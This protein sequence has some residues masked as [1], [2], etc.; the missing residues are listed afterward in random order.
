MRTM[1]SPRGWS[2]SCLATRSSPPLNAL[3]V[4]YA[5]ASAE[6]VAEF[7]AAHYPLDGSAMCSFLNRGFNDTYALRDAGGAQFVLRLSSAIPH[8]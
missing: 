4:I 2:G 1:G 3:P 5:T 7:V 8:F 6:A